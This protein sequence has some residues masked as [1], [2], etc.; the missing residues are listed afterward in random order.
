M[1]MNV[2]ASVQTLEGGGVSGLLLD[3]T[4]TCVLAF[5]EPISIHKDPTLLE[6][7]T[8]KRG[9]EIAIQHVY[10]KLQIEG[11]VKWSLIKLSLKMAIHLT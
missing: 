3:N 5:A 8:I 10:Y 1:K 4:R 9:M 2:D 11:N 7:M 6:A